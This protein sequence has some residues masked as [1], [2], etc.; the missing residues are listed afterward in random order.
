M[1]TSP[2]SQ[3]VLTEVELSQLDENMD[4][5]LLTR[6]TADSD[7]RKSVDNNKKEEKEGAVMGTYRQQYIHR[8]ST[9]Q[10][11]SRL[12]LKFL[13]DGSDTTIEESLNLC[14]CNHFTSVDAFGGVAGE[15]DN[16][17]G[18]FSPGGVDLFLKW[19]QAIDYG[20]HSVEINIWTF[21]YRLC[22]F[23]SRCIKV[24][25]APKADDLD[26]NF[27]S[28][29]QALEANLTLS[30]TTLRSEIL[31][32]SSDKYVVSE[33]KNVFIQ[34]TWIKKVHEYFY[35]LPSFCVTHFVSDVGEWYFSLVD[36]LGGYHVG[37]DETATGW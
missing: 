20:S 11:F 28:T 16:S 22:L 29:L 21:L 36:V 10:S 32:N 15:N 3:A 34:P 19:S 2:Q 17:I 12:M 13:Q 7:E 9:S 33:G 26:S 18:L 8:I 4:Y 30:L 6:I 1:G 23:S 31:D 37:I 5:N 14:W 35:S 24:K 25:K 27:M